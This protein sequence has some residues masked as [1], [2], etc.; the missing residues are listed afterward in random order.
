MGMTAEK[1]AEQYSISSEEQDAFAVESNQ[2]AAKAAE[3]GQF[4]EE[5]VAVE[6]KTRKI[7][8]GRQR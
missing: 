2:R 1:L 3:N 7:C 4:A 5:I 8:A 6:V